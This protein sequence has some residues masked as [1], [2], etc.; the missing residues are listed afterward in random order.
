[1]FGGADLR[2]SSTPPSVTK[3]GLPLVVIAPLSRFIDG[4]PIKP[5]TNR[6]AGRS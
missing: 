6:V 1:M 4:D 3:T 5:A 2:G